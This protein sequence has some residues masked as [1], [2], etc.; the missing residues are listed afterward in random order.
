MFHERIKGG[1]VSRTIRKTRIVVVTVR[2]TS[3]SIVTRIVGPTGSL[4]GIPSGKGLATKNSSR[5]SG[6]LQ[7]TSGRSHRV[8]GQE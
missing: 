2:K 5:A 1:S 7:T 8:R 6:R 3:F 4:A